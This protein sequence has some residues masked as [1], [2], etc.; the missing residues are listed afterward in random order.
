MGLFGE[1]FDSLNVISSDFRHCGPE[2]MAHDKLLTK[3]YVI[4]RQSNLTEN[5]NH[6]LDCLVRYFVFI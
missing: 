2:S 1:K 3:N 4:F 5:K 6:L